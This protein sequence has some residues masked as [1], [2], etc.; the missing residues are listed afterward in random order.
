[1]KT[2]YKMVLFLSIL[3]LISC[4]KKDELSVL[5]SEDLYGYWINPVV[6]DSISTFNKAN[7]LED[8]DYGFAFKSGHVFIERKN[9]GWCGTPPISYTDFEGTWTQTDSIIDITVGYWGGLADYQWKIM[10]I[11]KKKLKFIRLKEEYHL[12]N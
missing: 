2:A 5:D 12:E 11:D 4:D 10:S 3:I 1:M 9:S 6:N 8:D 7:S